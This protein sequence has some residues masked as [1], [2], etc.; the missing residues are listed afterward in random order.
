[1]FPCWEAA[2]LTEKNPDKGPAVGGHQDQ[3][4]KQKEPRQAGAM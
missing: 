1:M 4:K 3:L 2:G